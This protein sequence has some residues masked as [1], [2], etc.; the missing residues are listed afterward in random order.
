MS[1][2]GALMAPVTVSSS[3]SSAPGSTHGPVHSLTTTLSMGRPQDG[4]SGFHPVIPG[5]GVTLPP[6]TSIFGPGSGVVPTVSLTSDGRGQQT[7]SSTTSQQQQ[8]PPLV[9]KQ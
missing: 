5:A 8:Q 2:S 9:R 7:T 1:V 4:S 6:L 3:T